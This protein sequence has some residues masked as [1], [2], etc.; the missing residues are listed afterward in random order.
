MCNPACDRPCFTLDPPGLFVLPG[1]PADW[2]AIE[3]PSDRGRLFQLHPPVED[4]GIFIDAVP[5]SGEIAGHEARDAVAGFVRQY[6]LRYPISILE[7]PDGYA[8]SGTEQRAAAHFRR[9]ADDQHPEFDCVVM[10]IVRPQIAL[11]CT[12][13]GSPGSPSVD[14][15][16]R[17]FAAIRPAD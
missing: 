10:C 3:V 2:R 12:V 14:V 15:A 8:A 6:R 7:L 1:I 9:P 17:L 13:T 11:M 5:R 4:V 16:E